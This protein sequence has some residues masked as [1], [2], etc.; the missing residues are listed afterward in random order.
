MSGA[1]SA[2]EDG[3]PFVRRDGLELFFFSNRTGTLGMADIYSATRATTWDAWSEPVNLGSNV[4]SADGAETRPSLSADG[5]KLY[6]G[7]TRPGGEGSSD[8][9]VAAREG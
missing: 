1:N 8:H 5:T 3:Q 2:A 9:Y 7:S 6:F 4:N